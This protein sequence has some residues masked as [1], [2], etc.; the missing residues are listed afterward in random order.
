[1]KNVPNHQP[2]IL[3]SLVMNMINP[4]KT[5]ETNHPVEHRFT[6][7]YRSY[8]LYFI[9]HHI[10]FWTVISLLVSPLNWWWVTSHPISVPSEL[11]NGCSLKLQA[12][13]F[14][15]IPKNHHSRYP[16]TADYGHFFPTYPKTHQSLRPGTNMPHLD[17]LKP[18]SSWT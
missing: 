4:L 5:I 12:S 13:G 18:S 6:D 17:N 7:F 9:S 1:M 10:Q 11:A 3:E 16:E 15:A 8:Q 14:D 2:V